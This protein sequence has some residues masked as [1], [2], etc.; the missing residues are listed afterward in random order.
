MAFETVFKPKL[1]ECFQGKV[2]R[3]EFKYNYPDL[4]ERDLLASYFPIEGPTGVDRIAVVVGDITERKQAE[5]ALRTSERRQHKIAK[6]LEAERARLIEAQAVAK[7]G[8]WEAEL[9]SL[10]ITWSEQ[11]H[12]IFETDPSHFH[13]RRPD[14]VEFIHPEDRA[15][16]D[17]AFQ[18]SLDKIAPPNVEYRIVMAD[19]RVKVLEE[20]WRVFH[21]EQGRPIRLVGTCRDV[22]EQKQAEEALRDAKEFSENLIRT[23]NVIVLG[24][25]TR[26]ETSLCLIRQ[27]K[28]SLATHSRS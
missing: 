13:P 27:Q 10:E 19:G 16:V 20:Q 4:G 18:A 12:R 2:V 8:S 7:V 25:D 14:F 6:Q 5:E 24:L 28:K 17:A 21:D 9:P 26:G 22:T 1:D 23:A 3:F 11:T 15:K